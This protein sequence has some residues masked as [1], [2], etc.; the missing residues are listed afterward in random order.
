LLP[1]GQ[2]TETDLLDKLSLKDSRPLL[3]LNLPLIGLW[4]KILK[5]PYPVLSRRVKKKREAVAEAG[6]G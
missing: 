1:S 4:V 6:E 5:I 3:V 2:D